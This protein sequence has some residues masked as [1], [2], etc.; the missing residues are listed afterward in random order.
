MDETDTEEPDEF[1]RLLARLNEA[2]APEPETMSQS[3]VPAPV[4]A[5]PVGG[6]IPPLAAANPP[7]S[8]PPVAPA[9][10][11]AAPFPVQ[12]ALSTVAFPST[13]SAPVE[14]V[15]IARAPELMGADE[16]AAPPHAFPAP[17]ENTP[18][19]VTPPADGLPDSLPEAPPPQVPLADAALAPVVAP[20]PTAP[21]AGHGSSP[22]PRPT[23][24][25]AALLS[26]PFRNDDPSGSVAAPVSVGSAPP[27]DDERELARSTLGERIGLVVAFLIAPIGL[28]VGI[29]FAARSARRRG[30]VVGIV[31]ATIAVGVVLTIV[32]AIA[33]YYGYTQLK[34]QQ[35]HDQTAAASAAFCATLKAN[36]SMDQ[37]PTF[38][39]PAV[40]TS[41]PDSLK[42]MQAYEDRWTKLAKVSPSGIKPD[43]TKVAEAAKTIIDSVTVART[44]NDASNIAL[45]SS[46]AS[47]SG[48]PAWHSEYCG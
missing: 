30:W 40:A 17:W 14:E 1:A 38:G 4:A 39:W 42:A 19:P 21:A 35:E 25:F 22:A 16:L 11:T 12:A 18:P 26:T 45:M 27:D 34:L 5:A 33:G 13:P 28:I 3:P 41:I 31:R 32:L 10:G 9:F 37:L 15:V 29:V 6:P 2:P 43:V 7:P 46:V 44:V 47:A 36:P 20:A 24:D 8:S 48:V 23:V